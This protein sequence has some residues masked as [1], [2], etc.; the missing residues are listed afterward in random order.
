MDVSYR[1]AV[2]SGLAY[3]TTV[4]AAEAKMP[5]SD[6]FGYEAPILYQNSGFTAGSLDGFTATSSDFAVTVFQKGSP[7][8]TN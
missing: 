6:A 7:G 8:M 5:T 3:E 1:Y 2:F 4:A